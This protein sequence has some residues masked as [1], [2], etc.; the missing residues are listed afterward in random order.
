M[1][2]KIQIIL[3]DE[4]LQDLQLQTLLAVKKGIAQATGN[5]SNKPYLKL[6]DFTVWTGF[7]APTIRKFVANGLPVADVNGQKLYGKEEYIQWLKSREQTQE[8]ELV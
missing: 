3:T 7:T 4:Q 8:P 2:S 1:S 6:K 5:N